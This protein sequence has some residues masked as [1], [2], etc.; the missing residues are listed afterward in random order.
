MVFYDSDTGYYQ[1][2]AILSFI[3]VQGPIVTTTSAASIGSSGATLN[4]TVN[5]L[6][7]NGY[8]E[9]QGGT[10][11]TMNS[12]NQAC[13]PT[14]LAPN[15]AVQPFSC[16][17]SDLSSLTVYYFRLAAYDTDTGIW[18]YGLIQTFTTIDA[19]AATSAATAITSYSATL[20]G[21]VNP[22]G[23]S[24]YAIF[25]FGKDSTFG[26]YQQTTYLSITAN[27][28]A[29]AISLSTTT[30]YN[31][32]PLNSG[33]TYYFRL[34]FNNQS[35]GE[36]KYGPVQQFKT[37]I[38][39]AVT[40]TTSSPS[41]TTA[42]PLVLTASV[43]EGTGNPAPTGSVVLT[44]GGYTSAAISLSN[45]SAK[46]TIPA[47]SLAAGTDTLTVS[48][49]GDGN[50]TSGLGIASVTVSTTAQA[51]LVSPTPASTLPGSSVLFTW[52]A[53]TAATDYELFLGSTGKGSYD[54]YYSGNTTAT[55]A[56]VGGLPSN[57]KTVYARLYTKAN[58]TSQYFDYMY[59]AVPQALAVL[60]SPVP[61]STVPGTGVTFTWTA[62][63][64]T[65]DYEF[66][67]GST[68][69][70]S[71]NLYY[72]GNTLAT[73]ATVGG[74]PA[75]GE[76][77]YARL[78]TKF[79][80]VLE[81]N[82]YIYVAVAQAPAVLTAPMAGSTLPSTSVTFNWTAA[83]GATD[84]EL[85]IGSTGPGSY[86]LFYSGNTTATALKA[87]GLPTNGATLYAR[88]YT[89]FGAVLEYSD[90]TFKA[91]SQAP[92]ALT[93]PVQG[94]TFT[95][96]SVTFTWTAATGATDYELFVG[97]TGP[98]SYNLYYSGD[99]TVTSLAVNGLPTNGETIYAR[100]YTN[101][102]GALEYV[103]YTF[104]AK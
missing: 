30:S 5:P 36:T 67:V 6:G 79:G 17:I 70:G 39:P 104:T 77:L 63:P 32:V 15:S 43:S 69:P 93:S 28:T 19:V 92:A 88:L 23:S 51:V 60:T 71:Y 3:T 1:Y 94:S 98:G 101:F 46:I 52:S 14:A 35:N 80:G 50:Y 102:N 91:V 9:F 7:A 85:F 38:L 4:G 82:D 59:K 16:A 66:F 11:S 55:S 76:T 100:L 78:Y 34:V 2:G 29:Q 20:N 74:L 10:D 97:S 64:G 47:G 81:Y 57:G 12:Y 65:T 61:G 73:S 49:S 62:A 42:Q 25:E 96:A 37:L 86:N 48:Y 44:G 90:Y 68:G 21:T 99:K 45:G 53:A 83:I 87:G 33:T 26:T 13:W 95:G 75:N 89:K 41:I 72:S 40:V 8:T 58:G 31:Y 18:Q 84:Y 24:G 27:T 103:D 54:L 56:T 22:E